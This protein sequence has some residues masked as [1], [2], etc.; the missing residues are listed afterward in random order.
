M[1][2]SLCL[3]VE[4]V[5]AGAPFQTLLIHL[6]YLRKGLT[7]RGHLHLASSSGILI[8]FNFMTATLVVI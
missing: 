2:K 8:S 1:D 6:G 7:A 4:R 3:G 5:E